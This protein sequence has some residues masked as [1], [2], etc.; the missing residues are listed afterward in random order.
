MTVYCG[1][2]VGASRCSSGPMP[3]TKG[4]QSYLL[5]ITREEGGRNLGIFNCRAVR[6]GVSTSIHGVGRAGDVGTQVTNDWSWDVVERM[7][8][9]SAELG[10]QCIIHRRRIWS[11]SFCSAGWRHYD[12]VAAHFDH[13]HYELTPE[14]AA[15]PEA[16]VA[17]LWARVLGDPTPIRSDQYVI[18]PPVVSTPEVG[19]WRTIGMGDVSEPGTKGEQVRIDQANLIDTGFPVGRTGADGYWGNDAAAGCKNFQTA[20]GIGADGQCGP[21][22]REM[23]KRVPSWPA[24]S[25]QFQQR[26][27]DRGW[28]IS[29]DGVWGAKSTAVLRSFQGEKPGLVVDGKPGPASWTALWTRPL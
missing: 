12:G 17:A 16:E 24:S 28:K 3:G 23:L 25:R 22:T 14:M 4:A 6:G 8:L 2:Y 18:A 29:V 21:Q 9:L 26:L 5:G 7:R 20:A 1:P 11:S 13:W 10:I 15:R 19:A 27:R